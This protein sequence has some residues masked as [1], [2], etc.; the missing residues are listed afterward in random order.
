MI[1]FEKILILSGAVILGIGIAV[2][3]QIATGE[4]NVILAQSEFK[5]AT[6]Y[7]Q[8]LLKEIDVLYRD[9]KEKEEKL[10][11]YRENNSSS[12]DIM[13]QL[14]DELINNRILLGSNA[15]KGPGLS[16]TF[17]DGEKKE[18]EGADSMDSWLKTIH[19]EDMLKVING[20]KLNGGEVIEINGERVTVTTEI[21]CSWAFISINGK[22]LPAPFVVKVI[23]DQK[24]LLAYVSSTFGHVKIMENRGIQ[25][26]ILEANHMEIEGSIEMKAPLYLS[27]E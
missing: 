12:Q 20:L 25:V 24:K 23:G 7:K 4:K 17:T 13:K 6:E 19:N 27:E 1:K 16:L 5:D 3:F 15:A 11:I 9:Q 22:K 21:Y 10:A 8:K 26:E 2:L 14:E 18:G